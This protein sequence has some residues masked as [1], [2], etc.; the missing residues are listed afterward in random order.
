[1]KPCFIV[2]ELSAN[3]HND[4]AIAEQ[5]IRAMAKAGADAVKLQTYKPESLTLPLQNDYFGKPLS[6]GLWDGRTLWDLYAEAALR[7]EW[8]KPLMELAH[9][10]GMV[11]FSSPFDFEAVTFLESIGNPIYKIASFEIT[12]IPLIRACAATQKPVI[13]STGVATD[14]DIELALQACFAEGNHDVTLLK[15]T[16]QYPATIADANLLTMVDMRQRFKVQVGVS[17]H[18]AGHAV[19]VTAVALGATVVEKHFVLDRSLG[20]ADAAFSMEPDEFAAMVKAVRE[21]EHA[22]GKVTYAV[23]EKDKLRRR[24]LFVSRPMKAGEPFTNDNVKSL[25]GGQGL[26][27]TRL[28]EVLATVAACDIP[29]G[30]PLKE[31]FI[32]APTK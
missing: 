19:P 23:T 24:S 10:L 30:V 2:A 7:Y 15:C 11:C 17:D 1:M 6:G 28:P 9:E 14:S 22:L 29:A 8:H 16:S 13:I 32:G 4:L 5:T 20:G 18:T 26:A 3:H 12:D 27:P 21:T 31:S 25:R